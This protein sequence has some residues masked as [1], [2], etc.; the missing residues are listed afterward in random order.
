MK[1]LTTIKALI[2]QLI[3]HEKETGN[4]IGLVRIA[5][6]VEELSDCHKGLFTDDELS[7]IYL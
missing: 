5:G 4:Y 6:M 2:L 7:V 3:E 1:T